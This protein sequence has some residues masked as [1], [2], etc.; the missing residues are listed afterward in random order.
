M[1]ALLASTAV[2]VGGAAV[3]VVGRQV[4]GT[5]D[6]GP[7]VV[8][9]ALDVA[10]GDHPDLDADAVRRELAALAAEYRRLVGPD[11]SDE[12]R[13][14]AFAEV[15]FEIGGFASTETL[16]SSDALHVDTVLA[17]REGYCLSLSVV[18]LAIAEA[19]G[20]PLQVL[21]AP[22]HA[23]V[24]HVGDG[25]H[26]NL[27]LTRRGASLPDA[28]YAARVGDA[29]RRGGFYL[30]PLSLE[31]IHAM[32]LHNRGFARMAR[33][34]HEGARADLAAAV[35][36]APELPEAHRNLGVLRGEER[37]WEGAIACFE[38]ALRLHGSDADALLNLALCRHEQGDVAAALEALERTL[39]VDPSRERARALA[40]TWRAGHGP[41]LPAGS[42]APAD[43]PAGLEL[44]LVG[45]YY[46]DEGFGRLAVERVDRGLEF[47]WGR[48]RPV[49]GLPRDGSSIRWEGWLEAP[50]AGRY[51]FFLVVN[52]GVRIRVADRTVVDAW[53]DTGYDSWTA[54]YEIELA[55]GWHPITVE[56]LDSSGNA[57]LVCM[58][59]RQGDE[60]PLDL[61]Q[62][63]FH[64]GSR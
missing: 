61:A 35:A 49:R 53:G 17:G 43:A 54:A 31:E 38:E 42:R 4:P 59:G 62:H 55:A 7:D 51:T 28:H 8:A 5:P 37:D 15:L 13:A 57:R 25:G 52:D 41:V 18:A 10:R 56:Y 19:V 64:V 22:N 29:P 44:G 14:R 23:W 33:G 30:R 48:S 39:A 21:A 32:L 11:A 20:E 27:E 2:V 46:A 12:E 60:Y 34:E 50:E 9:V 6:T 16:E 58:I 3:A 47:D 36:L 26:V 63:L 1:K 24:R 40:A 45:R